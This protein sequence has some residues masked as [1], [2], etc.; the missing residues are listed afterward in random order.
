MMVAGL[1]AL[2]KLESL[3]ISFEPLFEGQTS[4]PDQRLASPLTR[5]VL[6]ALTR[7]LFVGARKYFEEF[8]AQLETPQLTDLTITFFSLESV[9]QVPELFQFICRAEYLKLA[10]F[11]RAHIDFNDVV[12]EISALIAHKR[13]FILVISI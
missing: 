2:T 4:H 12:T 9:V 7:F 13:N 6:P 8:V 11:R 1:T 3:R 10:E 5:I